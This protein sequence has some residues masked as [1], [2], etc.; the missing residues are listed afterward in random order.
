MLTTIVLKMLMTI[1]LLTSIIGAASIRLKSHSVSP[2]SSILIVSSIL[3][4]SYILNVSSICFLF[5]SVQ[6]KPNL[7]SHTYRTYCSEQ[8]VQLRDQINFLVFSV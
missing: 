6:T 4:V 7:N 1:M 3:D 8:Q 5:V 2:R